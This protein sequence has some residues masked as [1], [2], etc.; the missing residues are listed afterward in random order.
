MPI[1]HD[2]N[3]CPT[4]TVDI[5]LTHTVHNSGILEV[6]IRSC[7]TTCFNLLIRIW[8]SAIFKITCFRKNPI[9]ANLK[10]LVNVMSNCSYE[11]SPKPYLNYNNI[12]RFMFKLLALMRFCS[13]LFPM[14]VYHHA[15]GF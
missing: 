2:A 9:P 14:L 10:P 13:D 4:W 8:K 12:K 11:I 7:F 1:Y 6:A 5:S 3:Q 15:L